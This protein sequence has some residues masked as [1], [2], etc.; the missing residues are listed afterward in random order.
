MEDE[1]VVHGRG[2]RMPSSSVFV[3]RIAHGNA[4][5]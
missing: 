4:A 2:H 1:D 5:E 3:E